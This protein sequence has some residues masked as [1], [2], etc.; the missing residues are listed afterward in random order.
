MDKKGYAIGL[1]RKMQVIVLKYERI[2]YI[3]QDRSKKWVT[4]LKCVIINRDMIE[5]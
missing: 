1:V 2:V 4:L 3:M 5:V